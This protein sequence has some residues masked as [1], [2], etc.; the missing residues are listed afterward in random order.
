MKT[1]AMIAESS[2]A[3]SLSPGKTDGICVSL[4]AIIF[5]LLKSFSL[6][7]WL[8]VAVALS[9]LTLLWIRIYY[10][11]KNRGKGSEEP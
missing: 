1:N 3:I 4:G 10:S 11:L 9:T 5:G 7:D 6:K 2:R 8:E